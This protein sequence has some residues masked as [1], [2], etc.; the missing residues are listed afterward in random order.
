MSSQIQA[1]LLLF[2][3]VCGARGG[4]GWFINRTSQSLLILFVYV[5]RSREGEIGLPKS[6]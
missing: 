2:F 1:E 3:G 4:G 5:A 6:L